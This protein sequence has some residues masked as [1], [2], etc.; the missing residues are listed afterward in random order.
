MQVNGFQNA[1]QEIVQMFPSAPLGRIVYGL[2]S[3]PESVSQSGIYNNENFEVI[4]SSFMT[5]D[6]LWFFLGAY[7][8]ER[9]GFSHCSVHDKKQGPQD[10]CKR[11]TFLS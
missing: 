3:S 8:T 1:N 10:L 4:I 2:W 6:S 9:E 5:S 7:V 11:F